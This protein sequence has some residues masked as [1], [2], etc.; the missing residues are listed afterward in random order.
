MAFPGIISAQKVQEDWW[1]ILK[2]GSNIFSV[3]VCAFSGQIV[4][5]ELVF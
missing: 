4:D 1:V 5:R 2:D 3:F